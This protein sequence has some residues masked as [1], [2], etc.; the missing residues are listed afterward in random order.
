M[1]A[2]LVG[3]GQ[4]GQSTSGELPAMDATRNIEATRNRG[5]MTL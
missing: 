5:P 2:L 3:A 1:M 4:F